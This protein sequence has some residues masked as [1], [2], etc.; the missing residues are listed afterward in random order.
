MP[1]EPQGLLDGVSWDDLPPPAE[2]IDRSADAD[3]M[4]FIER[5]AKDAALRER[6]AQTEAEAISLS[7]D[8][9][10]LILPSLQDEH[11]ALGV[12]SP[13]GRVSKLTEQDWA[14]FNALKAYTAKLG[15]NVNRQQWQISEQGCAAFL[16]HE[17]AE[18][19]ADHARKYRNSIS[20]VVRALTDVVEQPVVRAA[21]WHM[22]EA[23]PDED[24][25][26]QTDEKKNG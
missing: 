23:G 3:F 7:E 17:A 15:T 25:K 13:S 21:M 2:P 18:H 14:A 4:A 19:G 10:A 9:E 12:T 8:I 24:N 1:K 11:C 16:I 6:E 20:R 26:P 5:A 22:C